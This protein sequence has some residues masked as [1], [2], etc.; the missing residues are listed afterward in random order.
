MEGKLD[1][2]LDLE[3]PSGQLEISCEIWNIIYTELSREN[4]L[5]SF[6]R[7]I[8]QEQIR[9]TGGHKE[10]MP[11]GYRRA[12]VQAPFRASQDLCW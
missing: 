7:R 6:I 4:F 10:A 2:Y 9:H 1:I 8:K 5:S 11:R 3:R 12:P